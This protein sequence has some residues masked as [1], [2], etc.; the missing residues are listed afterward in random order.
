MKFDPFTLR[1]ALSK[2]GSARGELYLDDGETFSHQEGQ[3]VWREFAAEKPSK[4]S[5]GVTIKSRDLGA[6]KPG[7][8][9]DHVALATYDSG[10]EYAKRIASVRVEKVVVLGLAGKPTRVS[11]GGKELQWSFTP[12]VAASEKSEGAASELV[13]KDPKLPVAADWEILVEA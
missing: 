6:Q 2:E 8:A 13:I 10:N 12:G 3:F 4:K 5:K 11:V 7:E 1:V 9:V